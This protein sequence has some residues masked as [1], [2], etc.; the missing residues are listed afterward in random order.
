MT[1]PPYR[2]P[3]P[4]VRLKPVGVE[5]LSGREREVLSLIAAGYS[6]D[7]IADILGVG[8]NT[9]KSYVRTAYGK[10]GVSRR[11][12]AVLWAVQHGLLDIPGITVVVDDV[13]VSDATGRAEGPDGDRPS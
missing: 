9:V 4:R 1:T 3:A 10:I 11:S 8:R 12:H 13:G 2:E 5:D 7:E 6:N